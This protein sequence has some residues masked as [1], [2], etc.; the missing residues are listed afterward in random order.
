VRWL[1]AIAVVLST[2]SCH[3]AFG[4]DHREPPDA[5]DVDAAPGPDLDQDGVLDDVDLCIA[6]SGEGATSDRDLDLMADATD[7]CPFD[8]INGADTDGDGIPSC[9]PFPN[10]P[11]RPDRVRCLM[12]FSDVTLNGALWR[13]RLPH[14]AWSSEP[15]KLIGDPELTV[16]D[17]ATTIVASSIEGANITTYDAIFQVD[18][19][20]PYG[21]LTLWLRADPAGESADDIGC[22]FVTEP[23]PNNTRF[24]V[25][26]GSTLMNPI[27]TMPLPTGAPQYVRIRGRIVTSGA[28][29]ELASV[30][31]HV[32]TNMLTADRTA[33]PPLSAGRFGVTVDRWHAEL[34]QLSIID[35]P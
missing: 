13:S 29:G 27:N 35:Q 28:I 11:A 18:P 30:T 8:A 34:T 7:P 6:P 15:F 1:L 20:T 24:G 14:R 33:A 4:L 32:D 9:D 26:R 10:L 2:S 16:Q 22:R 12:L 21:S 17:A 19:R 25:L 5:P 3:K 31:C 23:I